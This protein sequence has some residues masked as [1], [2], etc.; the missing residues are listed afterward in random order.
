VT[1]SY[2]ADNSKVQDLDHLIA[3]HLLGACFTLPPEHIPSYKSSV[4]HCFDTPGSREMPNSRLISSLRMHTDAR[5]SPSFGHQARNTSPANRWQGA[6]DGPSR[7][8][9]R[10]SSSGIQS[11]DIEIPKK[12]SGN[13][14]STELYMPLKT[15][16]SSARRIVIWKC[17]TLVQSSQLP[18]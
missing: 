14:G 13:R 15:P 12:T 3:V 8:R 18:H 9:R 4:D 6:Y 10:E 11:P 1:D 2:L 17:M 5:Y 16:L 7:S